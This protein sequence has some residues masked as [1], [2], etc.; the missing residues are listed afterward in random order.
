MRLTRGI[1]AISFT[2]FMLFL[3]YAAF[4]LVPSMPVDLFLRMD[5]LALVLAGTAGRA[6]LVKMIPAVLVLILSIFLGRFFCSMG[7]PLGTS[8]DVS[9]RLLQGKDPRRSPGKSMPR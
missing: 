6:F 5:P 8:I 9:D 7:C 2:A 4:P 1:Q 3:W